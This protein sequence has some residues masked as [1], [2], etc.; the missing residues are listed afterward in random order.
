MSN[1]N[2]YKPLEQCVTVDEIRAQWHDLLDR[3]Q[4]S[5]AN[6]TPGYQDAMLSFVG[7][8][9]LPPALKLAAVL[10]LGSAFDLDFRL[11]LGALAE[12]TME[13]DVPWPESVGASVSDNGPALRVAT[14]DAWL[15]AFIAG[16][17]AGLR[18]TLSHDGTRLDDWKAVFWDSF[19]EMACRHASRDDVRLALQHGASPCAG[20]YAAVRAAA[21][22]M[23]PDNGE[24]RDHG[25]PATTDADYENTL[26]QL[27]EADLPAHDMLA[28]SLRAAAEADNTAILEFL[29][30]QGADIRADGGRALAAAAGHLGFA[31]FEWLLE[32]GAD[33]NADNGAVLDAA[34]ASLTEGMV[35]AVLAAGADPG[36]CANRVFLTALD[37]SPWDLY[38]AETDFSGWRADIVALLLR[39][40]ARPAGLDVIDALQRAD[41]GLSI[42]DAAADHEELDDDGRRALRALAEQ[43]FGQ[44]AD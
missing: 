31:A 3:S 25:L 30:A 14:D 28:V 18:E 41:D 40:G 15:G 6:P 38:S 8:C 17:M 10:A 34:V 24:F 7:A 29:L 44:P 35:E 16:R 36:G 19:L 4:M 26:L 27:V 23:H 20:D 43:A 13:D 12:Q 11:A 22:G 21:R 5:P 33:I 1:L 9:A 39:H 32:H 37:A 2:W 42:L